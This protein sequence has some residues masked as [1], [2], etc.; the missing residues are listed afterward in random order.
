MKKAI[1][2]RDD[3]INSKKV[4]ELEG[5]HWAGA[6][7][8]TAI[9]T[10]VDERKATRSKAQNDLYWVWLRILSDHTGY[11]DLEE[12]RRLLQKKFLG[13]KHD[14]WNQAKTEH[15]T[16]VMGTS[17]LT[18]K[19]F[20]DYLEKVEHFALYTLDCKLPNEDDLYWQAMGVT[21]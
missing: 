11:S 5:H 15:I 7:G 4:S 20:R 2:K 10:I 6:K 8:D 17:K 12:L 9:I 19:A 14:F 13:M 21:D 3:P 1:L 18:V 16:E